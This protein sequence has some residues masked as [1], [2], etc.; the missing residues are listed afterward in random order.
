MSLRMPVDTRLSGGSVGG[1]DVEPVDIVAVVIL[2]VAFA[3]G[4]FRGLIRETFSVAALGGAC[5]VIKL[6]AA[7]L[8]L[9]LEAASQGQIGTMIAPWI[10]GGILGAIAIT[11]TI[12]VGRLLRRGSRWAGLGWLDRMAG[13]VLGTAE[14]ALVVSILLV[15]ASTLMGPTNPTLVASRSYN[16]LETVQGFARNG[17][18]ADLADVAAPPPSPSRRARRSR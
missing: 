2:G 5:I 6:F 14:G 8:G 10:A 3:R 13:G 4:L 9:K 17:S 1:V 11:A 16:A 12:T 7:P 15:L 18:W